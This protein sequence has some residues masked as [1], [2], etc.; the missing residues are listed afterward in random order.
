VTTVTTRTKAIVPTTAPRP[1]QPVQPAKPLIQSFDALGM[2]GGEDDMDGFGEFV[3][4]PKV[5]NK[6]VQPI[7]QQTTRSTPSTSS[8]PTSFPPSSSSVDTK[9]V[10]PKQPVTTTTTTSTTPVAPKKST[11]LAWDN[12]LIDLD[13]GTKATK[14]KTTQ[15]NMSPLTSMASLSSRGGGSSSSLADLPGIGFDHPPTL[16]PTVGPTYPGAGGRGLGL[17]PTSYGV[18]GPYGHPPPTTAYYPP[19][20]GFGGYPSYPPTYPPPTTGYGFPPSTGGFPPPTGGYPPT[21]SYP[22]TSGYQPRPTQDDIS[23]ILFS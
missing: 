20:T 13:L 9:H 4:A 18:P 3:S 6:S 22:P 11:E 23:K 17:G 19:T 15:V 14:P 2:G 7:P 21:A 10:Q 5:Q 12:N 16:G 8:F 1:V